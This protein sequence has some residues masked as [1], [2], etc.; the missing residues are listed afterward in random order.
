MKK[1]AAA[2]AVIAYCI[3]AGGEISLAEKIA[4]A[5]K[6]ADAAA[7]GKEESGLVVNGGFDFSKML[8]KYG[9][10]IAQSDK[11]A[12]PA[13]SEPET[14]PEPDLPQPAPSPATASDVKVVKTP[15]KSGDA[16]SKKVL[17]DAKEQDRAKIA[18]E[19][20]NKIARDTNKEAE[21]SPDAQPGGN[22]VV[23][24]DEVP[25]NPVKPKYVVDTSKLKNGY[26]IKDSSPLPQPEENS[27]PILSWSNSA[28]YLITDDGDCISLA[29]KILEGASSMFYE[30]ETGEGG[31][32]KLGDKIIV[33]IV[34]DA[35]KYKNAAQY[36]MDKNGGVT[37]TVL[38]NEKLDFAHFCRLVSGALFRKAIYERSGKVVRECPM[39]LDE[40]LSA[41]LQCRVKLGLTGEFA[42]IS[43]ENPP[44]PLKEILGKTAILSEIDSA[45]CFWA[46]KTLERLSS[47]SGKFW[48]LLMKLSAMDPQKSYAEIEKLNPQNFEIV[49]NCFISGE[50][51]S[52]VG[53][54]YNT[55]ASRGEIV[56]LSFLQAEDT[57]GEPLGLNPADAWK[58]RENTLVRYNIERRLMEIKVALPRI[59]PLYA[60][61][62]VNL[63]R[64]FEAALDDDK[65]EFDDASKAFAEKFAE[66][67]KVS[68][69]ARKMLS[70]N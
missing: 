51:W 34:T 47:R 64:V 63:G 13:P 20:D 6:M 69:T 67:D 2:V 29:R 50:I 10:E 68:D 39:W 59:N 53:G 70:G 58:Y 35:E 45:E 41:Y 27:E 60:E 62:L 46:L 23:L 40:A 14:A 11:T 54:V 36:S 19:Q 48:P 32:I 26:Y 33:Q 37:L 38:W 22:R 12:L 42:D 25:V 52:R 56:R 21:K 24:P 5:K 44:R 15:Q 65:D 49:W 8:E 30:F 7:A 43:A 31:D 61:A 3:A 1:I 4:L 17:V 28:F 18:K 16:D 57:S 55:R 9:S 66:A